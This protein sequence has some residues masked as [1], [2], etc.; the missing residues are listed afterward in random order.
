MTIETVTV[1]YPLDADPS[2]I[3][4]VSSSFDRLALRFGYRW[5]SRVQ[6]FGEINGV[7]YS[8]EERTAEVPDNHVPVEL[9]IITPNPRG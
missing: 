9:E 3:G 1:S 7:R 5:L 4:T 8:I 2:P 6:K